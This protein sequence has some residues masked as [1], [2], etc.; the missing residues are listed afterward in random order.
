VNPFEQE[1]SNVFFGHGPSLSRYTTGCQQKGVAAAERLTR[2]PAMKHRLIT[3]LIL[4][5]ACDNASEPTFET[6]AC[7]QFGVVEPVDVPQS[8]GIDIQGDGESVRVFAV[9]PV[10]RY[11]EMEDYATFCKTWDDVVRTEVLPCL[12]KDKPNLLVFPENASLSSAFIGSRGAVGRSETETLPAFLSLAQTYLEPIRYYAERYPDLTLGERLVLGVTD[13]MVRAFQTFPSIASHYGVYVAVSSDF[14]PA[15]LSRDPADIEVLADPDLDSVAGVYVATEGAAYNWGLYFGPDGREIARVAKSYLVPDEED[16]LSLSHGPLSQMR[17]VQLPFAKS[18]MVISKDAWMPGLL[19]R[20]D[21]LGANLN[22]QPEAFSGWAVEEYEGDWLPD[23]VRQSAWAHTQRHGSF[24]HTV[25]PCIKGNL[26]DLVFDCQSHVTSSAQPDDPLRAFIGQNPYHGL[27]AVEPWVIEDPGPSLSLEE[28]RDVLRDRGER[29]LPGSGDPLEDAYEGHVIAADLSLPADG[30][31]SPS[32]GGEAGAFGLSTVIAEPVVE[33]THQR[34]PTLAADSNAAVVAWMEG[35]PGEEVVRAF[36][37]DDG[38]AFEEIDVQGAQDTVQRLPR[39]AVGA[40]RMA[41]AW[42]EELS[43]ESIRVVVLTH[44]GQTWTRTELTEPEIAAAWEPD[45]AIDPLTGR[46]FVTWLDLRDGGRPKPWIARSDDG[47]TWQTTQ[48]DPAND[49]TDNPRGDAAFVRVKARNGN[50]YVAF[51][52]FREFSWDVYLSSSTDGGESFAPASRID[53]TAKSV[54][55]ASG[56]DPIESERIHGDVSL[57][58][59]AT[60]GPVVAWSERQDRRYES[61]IRVWQDEETGRADDAPDGI[62]AWRP[63]VTTNA[64][65]DVLVVWQDLRDVTN[66]VRLATATGGLVFESSARIDDA[67]IGANSYG[68]RIATL[69]GRTL[70]VWEDARSGYGRVRLAT[71]N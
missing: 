64:A 28:R 14:A 58:V 53:P 4:A 59:G 54:V 16:L 13:T 8:C 66:T 15:E 57:A 68:P 24:R 55:P 19:H 40:G 34:F 17:P 42:E 43:A 27:L 3:L 69:A 26:L 33:Q 21:A 1:D 20:L 7:E 47:Q 46:V 56:G 67:G 52:D 38:I 45:V 18:G 71:S 62:D 2:L 23:I 65:G 6:G 25:T 12:A 37:T 63:S 49:V 36:K 39:V 22:L 10:I 29:M 51:S 11:A 35:R 5:C 41:I 70:V 60:A 30:R 31:V 44:V 61:R 9:G 32:D 48:V 50:V